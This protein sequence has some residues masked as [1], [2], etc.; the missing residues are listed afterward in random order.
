MIKIRHVLLSKFR[1]LFFSDAPVISSACKI[2]DNAVVCRGCSIIGTVSIGDYT[3]INEYTRIDPNT[4]SIGKF[5]SI[6]HNVKIGMGPHP[7]SWVSTSPVFYS[8]NRGFVDKNSYD[9]CEDKGYTDI[10]NDVLIGASSII[11]AGVKIGNGAVVAA[12]SVVTKN[13]PD[14][15]I[16]GGNPASIIRYRFND[17]L[18]NE[19]LNSKWWELDIDLLLKLRPFFN[20]P[21]DFLKQI[22]KI[23]DKK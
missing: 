7:L 12:G 8:K 9:E 22:E 15:A 5:C 14:Y 23:R 16:A 1:S 17:K 11:L 3:Y 18:I 19:L 20:D 2:S 6:S 10:G 21:I 13:I 4:K